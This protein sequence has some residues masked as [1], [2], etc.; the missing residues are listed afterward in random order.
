MGLCQFK[1]AFGKPGEGAHKTRI[2]GVAAVDLLLTVAIAI[3]IG[4]WR[5]WGIGKIAL[6]FIGLMVLSVLVHK[7]FCVKTA[8]TQK[9]FK[10]SDVSA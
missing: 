6:F 4:L 5:K 7:A 9:I 1:D 3:V 8:L 2:F 10:D